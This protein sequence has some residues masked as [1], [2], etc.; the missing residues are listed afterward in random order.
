MIDKDNLIEIGKFQKAHALKGELNAIL[1][2]PEEYVE[3][4]NPLIVE[5]DGIPVPYYAESIRPKGSTSF[6]IK[7]EGIDSVEDAS[8]MVNS[9]IYIPKD[10]LQEY[11]GDVMYDEDIE[12]FK[13]IDKCFG[14][15]G[16]L[17]FIDDSTENQLMVVRNPDG[18]EIYIPLVDDFIIDI[19]DTNKEIHTSIPEGLLSLNK[20]ITD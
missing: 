17:E 14:E 15:I 9:A 19:D 7:L 18:E 3:N 8:E 4:G 12:G 5:T 10:V 2:I 20:K 16:E 13:V 1:N 6:L 11:I